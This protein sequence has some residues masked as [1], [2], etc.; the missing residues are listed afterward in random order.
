MASAPKRDG[1]LFTSIPT[2]VLLVAAI[3]LTG[4]GLVLLT[5]DRLADI[6]V[7]AL[8]L[9]LFALWKAVRRRRREPDESARR[10]MVNT[11]IGTLFLAVVVFLVA[12]AVPAAA[13]AFSF[14]AVLLLSALAFGVYE[15]WTWRQE[16]QDQSEV[17]A[18]GSPTSDVLERRKRTALILFASLAAVGVAAVMV[19]LV[20][21]P[22]P[23]FLLAIALPLAVTAAV[24]AY[25]L[26]N[27]NGAGQPPW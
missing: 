12:A 14:G 13:D 11:V 18:D 15:A 24:F 3:A 26:R 8:V 17:S 21:S 23:L 10:A 25:I 16:L 19:V 9:G 7:P 27:R 20:V 2:W 22:G 4:G 1:D 6:G 5:V